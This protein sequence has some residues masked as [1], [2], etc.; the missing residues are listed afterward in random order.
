M[1]GLLKDLKMGVSASRT[2]PETNTNDFCCENFPPEGIPLNSSTTRHFCAVY[3]TEETSLRRSMPSTGWL[4][5]LARHFGKTSPSRTDSPSP[6]AATSRGWP[7]THRTWQD[8]DGGVA[9]G[10]SSGSVIDVECGASRTP[11]SR[12]TTP[13]SLDMLEQDCSESRKLEEDLQKFEEELH[14][15]AEAVFRALPKSF[16][17]PPLS[18]ANSENLQIMRDAARE[19]ANLEQE[20]SPTTGRWSRVSGSST[21]SLGSSSYPR[22][23]PS[24]AASR[25]SAP[26]APLMRT[27]VH[28]HTEVSPKTSKI[29]LPAQVDLPDSPR[30]DSARGRLL[31]LGAAVLDHPLLAAS[32][33]GQYVIP[34]VIQPLYDRQ[35][36]APTPTSS[37]RCNTPVWDLDGEKRV[38]FLEPEVV[39]DKTSRAS[40]VASQY[41][42][43]VKNSARFTLN[44][45]NG[46]S[47]MQ[48]HNPRFCSCPCHFLPAARSS[49]TSA[50]ATAATPTAS[51]GVQRGHS[52]GVQVQRL[53]RRDGDGNEDDDEEEEELITTKAY[54]LYL[55]PSTKGLQDAGFLGKTFA[56]L[57]RALLSQLGLAIVV[58]AWWV[59]GAVVLAAVE[60]PPERTTRENMAAFRND[61]VIELATE[62][63][64]VRPYDWVWRA[65]IEAYME[66]LEA[67]VLEAAR[68]GYVSRAPTWTLTG[69]LLYSASLTTLIGPG[70]MVVRTGFSR[71]FTVLFTV[72]GAPLV[73]LV[74][75]SAARTF[76]LGLGRLWS[77]RC[78]CG[79]GGCGR[80]FDTHPRQYTDRAESAISTLEPSSIPPPPPPPESSEEVRREHQRSLSQGAYSLPDT[81][82]PRLDS[83]SSSFGGA[84]ASSASASS[85]NRV[86][87][88]QG[89]LTQTKRVPDMDATLRDHKRG[90]GRH[91][92]PSSSAGSST[93]PEM[94]GSDENGNARGGNR[95]RRRQTGLN[96]HRPPEDQQPQQQEEQLQ[97]QN[98]RPPEGSI[99]IDRSLFPKIIYCRNAAR[100]PWYF[101]FAILVLYILL[102][103]IIFAPILRWDVATAIYVLLSTFLTT[104]HSCLGDRLWV[105]VNKMVIPYI[106]YMFFGVIVFLAFL[107]SVWS[108]ITKG[109][110]NVGKYLRVVEPVYR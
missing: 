40:S 101:Y 43:I 105:G 87:P 33:R 38:R 71:V 57:T 69:A 22:Q 35:H 49:V 94:Y 24:S 74:V 91:R 109:L 85:S 31:D 102:G 37:T 80:V 47:E 97:I 52:I 96:G 59:V 107:L 65:K 53:P 4:A 45:P 60:G 5:A 62:L 12:P 78:G 25:L 16:P 27:H 68:A 95:R 46:G 1:F 61:L 39:G 19:Q 75:L 7:E 29:P 79:K 90:R 86:T 18:R 48:G 2:F 104:D 34:P 3:S 55:I 88:A 73:L 99:P 103:F 66:R 108:R 92:T 64:Q 6:T 13:W 56:M 77:W 15:S 11:P 42:N 76:R 32:L 63:R 28:G 10:L 72:V 23:R 70:G 110:V 93:S 82:S 100:I 14:S 20:V 106:I 58:V 50:T 21:L 30:Q 54:R 51:D 84:P 83:K 98:I 8:A 9:G 44:H 89:S 17:P 67:K 26:A 81:F 36:A 41:S